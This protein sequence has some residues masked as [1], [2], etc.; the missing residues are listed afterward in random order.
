MDTNGQ[1]GLLLEQAPLE[2]E[3]EVQKQP[4]RDSQDQE[5]SPAEGEGQQT[6]D[7]ADS[8]Y[9][10][11]QCIVDLR[12][13]LWPEDGDP[14]GRLVFICVTTHEDD[15]LVRFLRYAELGELPAPIRELLKQLEVALPERGRQAA[16]RRRQK[17]GEQRRTEERQKLIAA[18]RRP[19][20]QPKPVTSTPTLLSTTAQT[21]AREPQAP[22]QQT[23]QD[24][25][26]KLKTLPTGFGWSQ[27]QGEA[28][29]EYRIM[30]YRDG[31]A[32]TEWGSDP[33]EI[34]A[35]AELSIKAEVAA[36]NWKPQAGASAPAGQGMAQ[37]NLFGS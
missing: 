17:E 32:L 10:Y 37:T 15:P 7:G 34:F 28:G 19:T 20:Q 8:P 12:L 9:V 29:I 5:V 14:N 23:P 16:E 13:Q 4:A 22:P 36:K 1:P 24:A 33:E 21:A 31:A 18:A 3:E 11:D 25:T 6:A 27:R 30:R 2:G 35:R 26:V